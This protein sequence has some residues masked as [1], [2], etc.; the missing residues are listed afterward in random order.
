[1]TDH[2]ALG[3]RPTGFGISGPGVDARLANPQLIVHKKDRAPKSAAELRVS[4]RASGDNSDA[5]RCIMSIS[6][7]SSKSPSHNFLYA[8]TVAYISTTVVAAWFA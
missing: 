2:T 1:M 3:I 7:Q 4:K 8:R 6:G 5:A